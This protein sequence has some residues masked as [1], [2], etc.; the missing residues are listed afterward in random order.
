MTSTIKITE[1]HSSD[2]K[3]FGVFF[4]LL[5]LIYAG[6]LFVFWP[7][8]L[9]EDSR[10]ILLEVMNPDTQNSGKPVFWYYFVRIF[11][12]P[13]ER[14]ESPVFAML[15]ISAFIQAR[16]LGWCWARRFFKTAL[17]LFFF[18]SL[19]PHFVF[20][21]GSLYPD[22][23][24]AIGTAGLLFEIWL[25][26]KQRQTTA[27][28]LAIITISLPI[29]AFARA[30]GII[31]LL[32][33]IILI[34][35]ATPQGRWWLGSILMGWCSLMAV[36][37]QF[38]KSQGQ[39]V[40]Y[41]L[42][43]FETVNFLQPRPM[44]LWVAAPRISPLTVE[45]LQKYKP[46]DNYISYYDPD[47]WDTLVFQPEGPRVMSLSKQ[48]QK[49]I[50]KQFFKYNLWHNIPSFIGS[51]VNIFLVSALAQG[52]LPSFDYAEHVLKFTKSKSQYRQ[53]DLKSSENLLRAHYE[54]SYKYRFLLW[55]PFIGIGLLFWALRHGTIKRDL[56]LLIISAPML[57]Q[58]GA[59]FIFSIAG[60]Y[61][62][63]LPFFTLPLVLLP[64]LA[65]TKKH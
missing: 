8:V 44:N 51:R 40:L 19:A 30:N 31:F 1:E 22:G 3:F 13:H 56:A 33:F 50:T 27:L 18:I 2:A 47:Y 65:A 9:G 46:I 39:G 34:F 21:A 38:H 37:T 10:A 4:S 41:P 48:D 23:L 12:L 43:I 16:I 57:I 52:G 36:G 61:R 32:P 64:V 35:L 11:Y 45:T 59:I 25:I 60:E 49:I 63:I 7:G 54:L 24:F 15:M 26:A 20:F 17:F 42:A 6:W 53:H 5:A 58:L 14:V 55:T 28:S 29:A 62:Y